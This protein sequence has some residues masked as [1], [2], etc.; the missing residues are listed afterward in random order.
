M[1]MRLKTKIHKKE[2]ESGVLWGISWRVD[3]L[4][5]EVGDAMDVPRSTIPT[6]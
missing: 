4:G 3:S 1:D 6:C 2:T 5:R